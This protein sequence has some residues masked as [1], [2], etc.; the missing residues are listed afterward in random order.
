MNGG[1]LSGSYVKL[2]KWP[3]KWKKLFS[4]G[5]F[6]SSAQMN[7]LKIELRLIRTTWVQKCRPSQLHKLGPSI[8]SRS[9]LSLGPWGYVLHSSSSSS[10]Q[11]FLTLLPLHSV[12][13]GVPVVD[14]P[15]LLDD[16]PLP[17]H[18][19]VA[20]PVDHRAPVGPHGVGAPARRAVLRP[21]CNAIQDTK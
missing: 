15:A 17:P 13:H 3:S 9:Y 6:G 7:L 16:L 10:S 1:R 12:E 14:V 19:L 20:H 11:H 8:H 2:N 21:A 18:L 5:I 4:K